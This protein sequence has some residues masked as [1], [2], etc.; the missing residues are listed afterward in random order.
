MQET[1]VTVTWI[2]LCYQLLR[3]TGDSV[4]ADEIEKSVYN[5]LYGAVNTEKVK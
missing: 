3:I 4:Y 2:K 5:A 1:C